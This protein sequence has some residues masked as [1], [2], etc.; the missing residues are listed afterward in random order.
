M[1]RKNEVLVGLDI[2]TTKTTA[3]VG[4]VTNTGIDIIGIGTSPAKEIRK[5]AVVNIDNMVESIK[6]A[7]D[8]AEHMSGYRINSVYVGIAGN[9]VKGQNSLG[10]VSVK[11]REVGEDDVQRAIEA[12]RAIAVPIDR[13]IIHILPQNY[14]VDGQD[15]IKDPKGMSGV[16]LEAKV[17]IVTAASSA[18]QNIIK[19]VNRVGLDIDDIVMEQLAAS[20]AVLSSDEKDLGVAVIDI[21]G[22][23]TG[24]AI[25][26]EGS[27]KHTA[28]LSVGGNYVT[29][30]IATGLRT[31][32]NEAEG[33]KLKYGCALTSM[34]AKEETIRVPSVGGREDREV[35]RQILGRIVEPRMEEILS[36]AFKEVVRSG[37]EELLAA[38]VVL[39]GGTA[40]LPGTNELAERVFDMPTRRGNPANV[41][42]L[43]DVVN[44]PEHTVG[45][46][47]IVYGS[48]EMERDSVYGRKTNIFGRMSRSIKKLM[49]EFF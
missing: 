30:D 14:V 19:S 18:I 8:E 48:K 27:I 12:S 45:V 40:L 47:L 37:F 15:G 25:F 43:Y 29:S 9:H 2:G 6:T 17:H 49:S 36:F 7:V 20:E 32:L 28:I 31:P 42:G 3:V 22:A 10:I 44:S 39:T 16:R 23:H 26:A 21:G 35:S 34:I 13:E 4:E 38:G 41:G 11:G 33:I 24:I 5:G 1:G 46:G